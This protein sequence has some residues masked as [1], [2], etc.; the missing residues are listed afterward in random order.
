[1]THGEL[2]VGYACHYVFAHGFSVIP[3]GFDKKPLIKWKEYQDRRPTLRE[4]LEWPKENIAIVTGA[5]SNLAVID[6][7]S[8]ADADWFARNRGK[9]QV[10]VKTRRGYHFYFRHPGQQVMNGQR[11]EG[12]YDVRGDGGYVL[13]PPSKHADGHYEFMPDRHLTS[14]ADLPAFDPAWRTVAM[15]NGDARYYDAKEVADGCAYISKIQAVA[16]QGGHNDTYRAVC[17]LRASGLS[18]W[19]ALAAIVEWN[20][21][22]AQP[23]WALADLV[24]KINDV[25]GRD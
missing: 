13:A 25:Y 16:G 1:M 11:I 15:P 6:C 12:K 21:T 17:C 2:F 7:E 23:K 3:M 4:I 22:N 20:E 18:K 5:V 14:V 9:S 19:D 8:F 10:V 24:H